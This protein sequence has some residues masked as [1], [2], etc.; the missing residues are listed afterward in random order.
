[1]NLHVHLKYV[2]LIRKTNNKILFASLHKIVLS[3]IFSIQKEANTRKLV[4]LRKMLL[5]IKHK[6]KPHTRCSRLALHFIDLTARTYKN[7]QIA[8]M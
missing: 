5:D 3:Y 1:M 4:E 7:P 2:T 8:L 6:N